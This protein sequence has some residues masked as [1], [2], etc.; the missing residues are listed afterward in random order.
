M[1]GLMGALGALGAQQGQAGAPAQAIQWQSLVQALPVSTPGWTL[2]GEP[3]GESVA[4]GG[5]TSAQAECRLKQGT[6]EAK[7]EIV[8]TSVNP[9]LAMPFNMA[10]A[11]RIDS[12]EERMGPINF[13][14]YPGTQK[15]SKKSNTAEVMVM[16]HNRVLITVKVTNTASE[17]PAVGVMQYVSFA[18]LASL[19]G[20]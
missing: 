7:V 5:F 3:K 11:M 15:L 6:M 20:G 12:S 18:H 2:D 13:G 17:A 1:A 16:V 10:R 14:T 8:D 4:I 9:M 19:V